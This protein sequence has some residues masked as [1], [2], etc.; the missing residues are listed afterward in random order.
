LK[1]VA[2]VP[3][4]G[5]SERVPGK[6]LRQIAGKPLFCWIIETLQASK[7]VSRIVVDTDSEEIADATSTRFPDTQLHMRP[8][9][10]HGDFVPMHDIVA[11][12]VSVLE[13]DVFLQTHSTNP[14][15]K[16]QTVEAAVT[17]F[18]ESTEHD[19]LFSVTPLHTRLFFSDGAPVNHDPEVLQRT[20]DLDP[21]YE[22]NSSIYVVPRHVIEATGRRIGSR[23]LLFPMDRMEAIDID[24]EVDFAIAQFLLERSYG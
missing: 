9:H 16:S 15:L 11:H 1:V 4:K 20:Q 7:S 14:L 10:L 17:A 2:L 23:P 5:H 21:V 6:N 22:E 19:S 3:M 18:L 24:E 13:G 12:L 8:Q